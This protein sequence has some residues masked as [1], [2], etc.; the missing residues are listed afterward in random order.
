MAETLYTLDL[1][2]NPGQTLVS[3]PLL[4]GAKIVY[5]TREGMG[6]VLVGLTSPF[7]ER[8]YTFKTTGFF[9][10]K[11]RFYSASGS[12]QKIHVIYKL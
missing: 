3:H 8:E 7:T 1:V 11:L 5:L 4:Y 12:P 10:Y 9:A 2:Q 6:M